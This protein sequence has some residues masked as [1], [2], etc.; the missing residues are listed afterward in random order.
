MPTTD[1]VAT[2]AVD[3]GDIVLYISWSCV[4]QF[5]V[6]ARLHSVLQAMSVEVTSCTGL[7]EK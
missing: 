2:A 1:P 3:F 6:V 7:H 4:V 5:P